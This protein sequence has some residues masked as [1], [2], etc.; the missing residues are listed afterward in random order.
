MTRTSARKR[1]RGW[2]LIELM[3][4]LSIAG[5]LASFG[6]SF[7]TST[8]QAAHRF[9]AYSALLGALGRA[10]TAASLR[11]HAVRLCPSVDGANCL[12][13]FHWE[14]GW[15]AYVDLD[16][17]NRKDPADTVLDRQAA[18]PSGV[19]V[20]TSTGRRTIEF[21]PNGANAGSNATFTIC[22]GRGPAKA[23]SYAM[24]NVGGLREVPATAAAIA[25]ACR[26]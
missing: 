19:R 8:I 4:A 21:Q 6:V 7:A 12:D 20:I 23:K 15:L 13:A 18:L 2:T 26:R 5:I 16:D 1:Q 22:D 14:S 25:E 24:S 10:R 11:E 3:I 9:E 17:D